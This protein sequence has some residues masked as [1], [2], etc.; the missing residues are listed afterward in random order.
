[1]INKNKNDL[2]I[3]SGLSGAGKS[4]ALI[5]LEASIDT[6]IRRFKETRRAHPLSEKGQE[7]LTE[8]IDEEIKLLASFREFSDNII[9]TSNL[10]ANDFKDKVKRVYGDGIQ[11]MLVSFVSFGF[12]Q[13]ILYVFLR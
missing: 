11:D 1:M 2:L 12:K 5:A 6:L 8:A 4:T 3:V 7:N 13:G 10:R 9:D